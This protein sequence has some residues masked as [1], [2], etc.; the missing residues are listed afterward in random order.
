MCH[1][2][3]VVSSRVTESVVRLCRSVEGGQRQMWIFYH[4]RNLRGVTETLRQE[5]SLRQENKVEKGSE[6]Y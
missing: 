2:P 5:D 4:L 6:L 1:V 3:L